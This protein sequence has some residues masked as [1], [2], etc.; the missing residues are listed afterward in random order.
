M[1]PSALY[2]LANWPQ[3]YHLK[4]DD[5]QRTSLDLLEPRTPLCLEIGLVAVHALLTSAIAYLTRI[6]TGLEMP[7]SWMPGY[8]TSQPGST[9]LTANGKTQFR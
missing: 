4:P 3:H 9:V 6:A 7:P 2:W 8:D 1:V 5:H